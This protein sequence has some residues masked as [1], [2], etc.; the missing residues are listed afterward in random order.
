ME[1]KEKP[2]FT[3][4][5]RFHHKY[6]NNQ[7]IISIIRGLFLSGKKLTAKEINDITGSND[8][9]KAISTLRQQGFPIVDILQP[10]HCKLY[11]QMPDNRQLNLFGREAQD[12]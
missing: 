4:A 1:E 6:T 5:Q 2:A 8:A 9:R 12:E 10:N 11:W 7:R 3:G